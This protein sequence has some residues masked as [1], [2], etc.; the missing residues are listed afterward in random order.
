MALDRRR[1]RVDR[2][3]RYAVAASWTGRK[4]R[5]KRMGRDLLSRRSVPVRRR[6]HA[7]AALRAAPSSLFA[8]LRQAAAESPR[9]LHCVR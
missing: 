4:R 6:A 8:R 3:A 2:R 9:L 1:R 7:G 5:R